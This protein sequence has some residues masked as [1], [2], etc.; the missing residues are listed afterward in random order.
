MIPSAPRP[1]RMDALFETL[2]RYLHLVNIE[3][4]ADDDPQVIFESLNGRGVPLLPSDL[5]RN[6]V[7]LKADRSG[8]DLDALYGKYW[9]SYDERRQLG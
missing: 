7:F 6:F 2:R 5:I 3:L 8:A 4:E 9:R 1:T